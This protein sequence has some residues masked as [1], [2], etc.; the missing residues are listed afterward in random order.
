MLANTRTIIAL[1]IAG[2][3]FAVGITHIL[4]SPDLVWEFSIPT[5][6]V[7]SS[8]EAYFETV[9]D[10]Q[11]TSGT[12]HSPSVRIK[13]DGFSLIWFDGTRESHADVII[14]QADFTKTAAGWTSSKAK[15][16]LNKEAMASVSEPRQVIL[17]LGNTIQY[18]T[19]ETSILATIVS[20]GGWAAASI[21]KVDL[22][23][24]RPVLTQKLSLSPFLNR[25][26][27]VRSRT[28]PYADASIAIPA[29][30]ELGNAFGELVRLDANGR[31]RDKRR[32]SQ[33]RFGIQPEIVPLSKDE[34]V[35][36]MRNFDDETSQ[37]IATWTY[38]GGKHWT[39]ATLLDVPNPNSPIAA[40]RISTGQILMAF[41]D[42]SE[43]ATNLR[44]A[45]SN[46][47]GKTWKN[48]HTVED[49]DSVVRYPVMTRLQDG[50]IFLGYS[51]N[52]KKGLR[53]HVFNE[54]WI[55]Q[56]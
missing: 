34:A 33:G 41:N 13:Q 47:D 52:S 6:N 26:H 46:D 19:D 1:G 29:Y 51:Y 8:K 28:I 35:A 21:A 24:D 45:L 9:F 10:Y 18:G 25:S 22:L 53:G 37:L 56:K 43:S 31:V 39:D 16:F 2:L 32:M 20:I 4:K 5:I 27:L 48:I 30:L 7:E 54:N 11:N 49:G 44:L 36:L 55:L 38:D 42:S 3:S 14:K 40:L 17:S 12:A 15:P 50:S 23:E